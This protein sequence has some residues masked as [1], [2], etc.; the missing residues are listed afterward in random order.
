[1]S[2]R[3]KPSRIWLELQLSL[4]MY[5]H[6]HGSPKLA[7]WLDPFHRMEVRDYRKGRRNSV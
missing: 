4:S 1:M 2:Y 7:R 5:F 6:T 3:W